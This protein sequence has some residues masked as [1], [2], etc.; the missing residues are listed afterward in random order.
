M[1]A[2]T[3]RAVFVAAA[4]L[5]ERL[6]GGRAIAIATTLSASP[7]H[8]LFV[9]AAVES[10]GLRSRGRQ[11]TRGVQCWRAMRLTKTPFA[12]P[13]LVEAEGAFAAAS[14]TRLTAPCGG[15]ALARALVMSPRAA[16]PLLV[17]QRRRRALT[18]A[19]AEGR[20]LG[21][22]DPSSLRHDGKF[23]PRSSG[24]VAESGG[25]RGRWSCMESRC[26]QRGTSVRGCWV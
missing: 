4:V 16:N 25:S 26:L 24:A 8:G 1:F 10:S 13:S 20:D 7:S 2:A 9:H 21:R 22:R 17:W 19:G 12:G 14:R 5:R 3:P 6:F 18:G 11:A 15:G 23:S